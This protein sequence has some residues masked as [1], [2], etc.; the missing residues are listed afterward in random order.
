MTD[1]DLHADDPDAP[2]AQAPERDPDTADI[3]G[4]GEAE[5]APAKAPA[6]APEPG[7]AYTVLARK[8]RPQTFEDLIGQEAM[9]RTLTNAFSAGRIAHAFMLTGVRGVGKTTT[10]RLL[11]RA[12]NYESDTVHQPSVDLGV[13]G[14]HCKAIIEGRHI[15]VLELDAASRTKVD[16][17]REL[18]DG[19]RYAPVEARYK[20]YVIDEVHMLSTAA[21]N[22]LLKTLE[23]PPPHA[24]FIFAT[25][26]IRKVPVTILSRTQRFD[27]RRVEPEVLV[28]HLEKVVSAEGALLESEG[29]ALIARAAE[30]SVR[31]SLSLLDQALVQ[32]ERGQIVRADV[33]RDMLG[34]ADRAQTIALFES[35]LGGRTA[36]ALEQF[37]T[38]YGF[39]ADPAQVVNDLLEHAH[40]ATVAKTLGPDATRLPNDQAQRLAALGAT[41]SAGSLSRVWQMLLKAYDEVRRAPD[42]AA[43]TE[44]AIV[45]LAYA[46]DL[47][48]PEEALKRL[49]SG[50]PAGGGSGPQSSGPSGG[51]NVTSFGAAAQMRPAPAPEPMARPQSF[52][53]V[54]AL[55]ASRR[56]IGL[57]MD[58]ERFVRL[59]SFKPGAIV[60]EPAPGAPSDLSRKL[61]LRLKE[62]TGQTWLVAAE[63][64]GGGESLYERERRQE[65]EARAKL[66]QDPFVQDVLKTFP[67]AEI[68]AIRRLAVEATPAPSEGTTDDPDDD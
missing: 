61:S 4:G 42:P 59:V 58:V 57:R 43:A 19:V 52:E 40:G 30:G 16:E 1:A 55:I 51:G 38:L 14:R 63:G 50:A 46:S 15:D 10:A 41:V 66:E 5:A 48:G 68:V 22:A 28:K 54:V 24:K 60:F 21:F 27:L 53:E 20:V 12:L 44:M 33:V 3:F 23:E 18:L 62:W 67:G 29:L 64:G 34:L 35:I 26:E 39:G 47:P 6:P 9:V 2:D 32:A 7:A 31:D 65:G 13:E 36:E 45:R 17:M 49:Q 56:D 25:T 11:A 8:Y 37:R